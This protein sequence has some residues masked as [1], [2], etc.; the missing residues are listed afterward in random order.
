MPR[1]RYDPVDTPTTTDVAAILRARTKDLDGAEVGDFNANTRPTGPEVD[2]LI[3]MAYAEVTGISG[4]DL[5]KRCAGLA[6]SLVVIRAAMWVEGS[7]WPEQVRTDRS[8]FTELAAQY[9]AGL[10]TLI[11]CAAGNLPADGGDTED[12]ASFRFGMLDVHGWTSV[13]W[14]Y[15]EPPLYPYDTP[16]DG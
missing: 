8:I 3:A 7:Y 1:L 2:R 10:P 4:T 13:P 5:A 12:V 15:G 6:Y 16:T 9:A 14:P 11:D